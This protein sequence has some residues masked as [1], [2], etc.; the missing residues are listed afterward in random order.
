MFGKKSGVLRSRSLSFTDSSSSK[1]MGWLKV[2][3]SMV[4]KTVV[5]SSGVGGGKGEGRERERGKGVVGVVVVT[6]ARTVWPPHVCGDRDGD[7]RRKSEP[8]P[9]VSSLDSSSW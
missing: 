9:I 5:V 7:Q 3:S 2:R 4:A 1:L 8:A 6:K